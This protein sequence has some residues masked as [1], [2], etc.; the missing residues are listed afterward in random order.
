[1]Q[2]LLVIEQSSTLSNLLK[3]TLRAGGFEH[4]TVMQNFTEARHLIADSIRAE[5]P[6]RGIVI[7]IPARIDD[8]L[9]TLL[10][11]LHHE[12]TSALP[13]LIVI[14]DKYPVLDRWTE[15]RGNAEV[16]P[17]QRFSQIPGVLEPML[18]PISVH[19]PTKIS[20]R[21]PD[22]A[23]V[24]VL[25]VDDSKSARYTYRQLLEER[26]YP[27]EV[28]ASVN[29]ALR[30]A[31][32][33]HFDLFILDF[34]L[35]D[36][37][38]AE[39]CQQLKESPHSKLA[40]VAVITGSYRE[41]IIQLCL[42]AGAV[43]CMFKNEAKEL[44]ITR[45]NSIARSIES[46]RSVESERRRL[47]GILSSVGDGVYGIDQAGELTFINRT[48]ADLLGF[49]DP[50]EMVGSTARELLHFG[51]EGSSDNL[52][53]TA[54]RSGE[55]LTAHE[56]VFR[57]K[58]GRP[59][60][61]ECT[62]FPLAIDNQREGSVVV[63]RD[64]SERKSV[65]QLRWEVTHD[66][67]TGLA[68]RR[69]FSQYLDKEL[70]RLH[71]TGGYN[72]LLYI[73]LDRFAT[74]VEAGGEAEGDR[75]L[76]DVAHKLGERL[77]DAD[78]LARLENDKYA[79]VLSGISLSNLFT[80][81]D[82]YR[83]L[84]GETEYNYHGI[85]RPV[86][87]SVGVAILSRH[88]PSA[89]YALEHGRIACENAKN[90]GRN[91]TYI[92]IA[93]DD[94]RTAQEFESGWKDRFKEALRNDRF[95]FLIQPIVLAGPVTP[96]W[97]PTLALM[98]EPPVGHQE[99]LMEILLRML[100]SDGKWISPSV[101]VP[102]AERLNM[103]Q[104]MDLWVV[105]NV[106]RRLS[107]LE[108]PMYK[109]CFTVNLSNVTLQDPDALGLIQQV[110]AAGDIDASRIVFE[111][112]ETAQIGDLH[113]AR[114]FIV[115]LKKLGCRFALDDF[116]TG[117]SS[118][119]HLKHLPV[120]FIKIDGQFV[121]AMTNDEIDRTMVNSITTMAHSLKLKTIAEH[122]DSPDTLV[123]AQQA[124]VDYAQGH[125]FGEPFELDK[126]DLAELFH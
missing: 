28:A 63:F 33:Q 91:Q 121:Q 56:T 106:I 20:G 69:H 45:V 46:Q 61:V 62:V 34:Y 84:I 15:A 54:Y 90:K 51:T 92:Y 10:K 88:T 31:A 37:T 116:G 98:P 13:L 109:V 89:E 108:H 4:I 87:A 55:R 77:R 50:L 43:E 73:D 23:G 47:N 32:K 97:D 18:P 96:H 99:L 103:V 44:F 59:I 22:G 53:N 38:G 48:G 30:I 29:E 49:E 42:E 79:L 7:G 71:E 58:N 110:I 19:Q 2:G 60:P 24:Q 9:R 123:A 95:T 117:F 52:L 85:W 14:H 100:T 126:L 112:T 6:Y 105:R 118:F 102:L 70:T 111:V 66:P 67:L 75:I 124:N 12:R 27:V 114:R 41:K 5:Q 74:M 93:E 113:V 35:P 17:W 64:I 81:A 82:D 125:F 107:Q 120:D 86:T 65:E 72:A 11:F 16:L 122:V 83:A 36:G 76:A 25:F 68:N 101:F 8:S 104:E 119:T 21:A 78:M 40:T 80:I 3:R 39:L 94:A 115:E 1:M 57:H 26:G